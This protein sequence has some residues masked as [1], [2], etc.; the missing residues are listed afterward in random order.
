MLCWQ[1]YKKYCKRKGG[2]KGQTTQKMRTCSG[3]KIKGT[4]GKK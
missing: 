1:D 2:K 4:G 3:G